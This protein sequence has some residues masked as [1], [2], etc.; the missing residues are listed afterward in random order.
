MMV[1]I[2]DFILIIILIEWL[3]VGAIGIAVGNKMLQGSSPQMVGA[4]IDGVPSP[5]PPQSSINQAQLQDAYKQGFQEAVKQMQAQQ[6]QSQ[7]QQMP[8]G[9]PPLPQS[10]ST[11]SPSP[12]GPTK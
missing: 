1:K 3:I 5:T 6:Q 12:Y 8:P 9:I 4:S 11:P 2:R 7:G 10:Q